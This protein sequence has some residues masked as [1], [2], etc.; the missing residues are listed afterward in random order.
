VDGSEPAQ[1]SLLA[2]CDLA[3]VFRGRAVVGGLAEEPKPQ[4]GRPQAMLYPLT[5]QPIFKERVWGGRNL[6]RLYGKPL[7]PGRPIGESWELTDRPP[8]DVSVIAQGPLAGRTLRWLMERHRAELLGQAADSA[9]RFPLLIKWL[10]AQETLSLQVH[11]PASAAAQLGGEPKTELW[12][13]VEARPGAMLFAGLKPGISRTDF[14]QALRAG[15]VAD[16]VQALPVQA[17]DALLLPAGRLHA[18]GAGVVVLEIQQNS[19]T[20]YRVFDWNR[21]GPDGRPRPLH[22]EQALASIDFADTAPALI[23]SAYSRNPTVSV[24]YVVDHPLFSVNACKI[25]RGTRFYVRGTTPQILVLL[26][27]RLVV[28][29]QDY[30]LTLS[31]GQ[32]VLLAA[33][34]ER[35]ALSAQTQVELVQI[36]PG[37]GT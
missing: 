26:R 7:P 34:L 9:G 22:V 21:L 11:P 13:V 24:R 12:Y 36:E 5:F 30:E 20:T 1:S 10:D 23:R 6:E 15:T 14:E 33:G 2:A 35:T 19:D 16:C 18:L 32:L 8:D 27:G 37:T 31:P 17:G 25:K 3:L 4:L 29:Y 28:A